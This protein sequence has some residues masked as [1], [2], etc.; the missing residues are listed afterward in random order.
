MY[1]QS[2]KLLDEREVRVSEKAAEANA[3]RVELGVRQADLGSLEAAAAARM[4]QAQALEQVRVDAQPGAACAVRGPVSFFHKALLLQT[5]A[6]GHG[7]FAA[8][9]TS[10]VRLGVLSAY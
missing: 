3:L 2:V 4:E 8:L 9:H 7:H 5:Q 1:L 6:S 10:F